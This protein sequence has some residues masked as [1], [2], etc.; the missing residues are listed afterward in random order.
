MNSDCT[1]VQRNGIGTT[2]EFSA[3]DDSYIPSL[4]KLA[5]AIKSGGAPAILQIF[6]AG[7]KAAAALIPDGDVVSPS[8]VYDRVSADAP[9]PRELSDQE[10][11]EIIHAFGE[12]TRRAIE[13][14]F[15]GIELHGAHGFLL[16]SFLSPYFNRRQDRWGGNLENRLRLPLAVVHEVK[17]TIDKQANRP[18][19][20]GYRISPEEHQEDALRVEDTYAMIDRLIEENVDYVHFSLMDAHAANPRYGNK[21]NKTFLELF[22]DYIHG[23]IPIIAAG[24]LESPEDDSLAIH[25][26]ISMAAIGRAL[27][28]DPDWVQKVSEGREAEIQTVMKAAELDK[29]AIPQK[30]WQFILSSGSFFKVEN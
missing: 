26:G 8:G 10:I 14:G 12:T 11:M 6:H 28:M 27:I 2:N 9:S 29:L 18:F 21:D 5:D 1:H 7:D 23:Q 13:A 22:V 17:Q 25:K 30:L 4:K 16:Q 20:L 15:D 24:S 3:Y 19:I